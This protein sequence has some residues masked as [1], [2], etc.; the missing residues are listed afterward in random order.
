MRKFYAVVAPGIDR[1]FD[2]PA[3]APLIAPRALLA[4]IGDS[5]PRTPPPSL[6]LA[7][8]AAQAAYH[9]AGADDHFAVRIQKNRA[10]GE[11]RFGA[12]GD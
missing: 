9:A 10:Q 2:G 5:D 8:D 7:T 12:R 1:E 11:S 6:K 4:V 3:M